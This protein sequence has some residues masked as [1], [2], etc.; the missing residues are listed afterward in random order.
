MVVAALRWS[1]TDRDGLTLRQIY[2]QN[3]STA[4]FTPTV[5]VMA[6]VGQA[7]SLCFYCLIPSGDYKRKIIIITG[8]S[9]ITMG[10]VASLQ[11]SDNV[12]T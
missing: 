12:T 1:T 5:S 6:W 10:T 2:G 7:R 8:T 9:L 3:L 4:T 11:Y